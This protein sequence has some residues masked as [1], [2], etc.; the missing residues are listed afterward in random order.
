MTQITNNN[1]HNRPHAVYRL[2]SATG[3]LLYVGCSC[4]PLGRRLLEHINERPWIKEAALFDWTEWY[5]DWPT[6]AAAE[7]RAIE[8]ER[9]KYNKRRVFPTPTGFRSSHA[10]GDLVH[11]PNCGALIPTGLKQ[12]PA[13][14]RACLAKDRARRRA[15]RRADGLKVT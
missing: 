11:C 12:R 5:P 10:L 6:A 1:K 15:D 7:A 9:P 4:N 3:E 13:H 14:C 2:K 8:T